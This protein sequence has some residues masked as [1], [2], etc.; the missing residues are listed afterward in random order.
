MRFSEQLDGIVVWLKLCGRYG[1][2][3][4]NQP[5]C[6][7]GTDRCYITTH[8]HGFAVVS[9][10]LPPEW[11]TLFRNANDQTN[12][13]LVH[14]TKPVFTV[15]FHPEGKGGPHDLESLFDVFLDTVREYKSSGGQLVG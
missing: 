6:L 5:C 13:G 9:D 7:M 10:S 8:N 14:K 1:H 12:E 2:R 15:Q 3:G 4:H 11:L